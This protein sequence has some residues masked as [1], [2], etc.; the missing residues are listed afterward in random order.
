MKLKLLEKINESLDEKKI[1]NEIEQFL[2]K[3]KHGNNIQEH[4]K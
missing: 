3:C 1:K 2:L 4:G